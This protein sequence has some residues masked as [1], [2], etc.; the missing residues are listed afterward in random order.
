MY[1]SGNL[2][3]GVHPEHYIHCDGMQLK[4]A[5]SDLG[6]EQYSNNDYYVWSAGT[7]HTQF[8][9]LFPTR[10]TLTTITLHYYSDS[11]RGLSKL[12]FLAVPED[13]DIW[14]AI[15]ASH[16]GSAVVA[17][18]PP[19]REPVGRRNVSFNVNFNTKKVLMYKVRSN[20]QFAVSEVEFFTCNGK[21]IVQYSYI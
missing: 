7:S 12:R 4:L 18:V 21:A 20:F 2:P 14:N 13:F 8:L 9:F 17:A 11:V 6:P 16:F 3:E 1:P 10:V 15:T 19:G 5:D